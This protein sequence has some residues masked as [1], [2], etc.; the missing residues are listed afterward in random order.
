MNDWNRLE[1]QLRSWK[2]RQP[3]PGLK[4]RLFPNGSAGVESELSWATALH[5][6]AP[7]LAVLCLST[8]M[9]AR[10]P[11]NFTVPSALSLVSCDYVAAAPG[12]HNIWPRATFDWTNSSGSTST[13]P[14]LDFLSTNNSKF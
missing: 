8:F 3:S 14:S 13:T 7:A 12:D 11:G 10:P 1:N 2:P 4:A 5:W 6:F 9:L